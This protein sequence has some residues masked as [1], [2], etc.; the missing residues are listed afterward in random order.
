[1]GGRRGEVKSASATTG[2]WTVSGPMMDDN[3]TRSIKAQKLSELFITL[4]PAECKHSGRKQGTSKVKQAGAGHL[5]PPE[6]QDME[7]QQPARD[8]PDQG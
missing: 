4:L 8:W 5:L 1:M 3:M 7:T 2:T 6:E